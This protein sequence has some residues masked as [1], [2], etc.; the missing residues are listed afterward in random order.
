[1]YWDEGATASRQGTV[2]MGHHVRNQLGGCLGIGPLHDEWPGSGVLAKRL[3]PGARV[4][5]SAARDE[6][7]ALRTPLLGDLRQASTQIACT[8]I[9]G[10]DLPQGGVPSARG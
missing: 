6:Q 2:V 8:P 5:S 7:S 10:N 3:A 4:V 1:M 9:L